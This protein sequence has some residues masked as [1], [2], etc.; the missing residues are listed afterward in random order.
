MKRF[1][2]LA[3]VS[4]VALVG[5]GAALAAGTPHPNWTAAVSQRANGSHTLGNPDAKVKV[6]EYVS[7]TCS[8]CANFTKQSDAGMRL[9]YVM[10]GKASVTVHHLIRDP[11][12]L[13][14]A[15][16]VNCGDNKGFFRR[17]NAFMATQDK[18]LA[19]A[20][21]ASEATQSR[22]SNGQVSARMKAIADDL[23][24][25]ASM[26]QWGYSRPAVDQ[27]LSDQAKAKAILDQTR[28]ASEL[29][30]NGTPSFAINGEL[31]SG[32]HDWAGLE[33]AMK[34]SL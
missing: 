13:T 8:H 28:E 21:T 33:I 2:V 11:I 26:Q 6:T 25:Y 3:A 18:W 30:I 15:M 1:V 29:G 34:A 7:Y 24:F 27:C 23:G 9:A 32:V 10:P 4:F 22:W 19:K 12:D 5:S 31:L 14:V 17:H 16:L 20:Q